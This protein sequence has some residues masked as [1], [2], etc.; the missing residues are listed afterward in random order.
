MVLNHFR[1]GAKRK[2]NQCYNPVGWVS[3]AIHNPGFDQFPKQPEKEN[4][5]AGLY[6]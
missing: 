6:I 2:Q 4:G 3:C 5:C 1:T